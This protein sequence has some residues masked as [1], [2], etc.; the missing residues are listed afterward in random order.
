V[1][2][3]YKD[4]D[5]QRQATK[6]A[7]RR[8]RKSITNSITNKGI[9]PKIASF[10]VIPGQRVYGRQAVRYDLQEAW[11][12]RPEPE[13]SEDRPKPLNRGKYIKPD[14]SEYQIDATG[15]I[16][17][18]STKMDE[19]TANYGQP[20]CECMHCQQNR[21]SKHP[22]LINHGPYRPV[23]LLKHN[24]VNRVSLPGDV[25]YKGN[26]KLKANQAEIAAIEATVKGVENEAEVPEGVAPQGGGA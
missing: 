25:D 8:Y 12:L 7:T 13:S 17:R 26:D 11:D 18:L 1:I 21:R 20:N 2:M 23:E 14:G 24:E 9:T 22:R 16:H 10:E 4:K 6:E 15:V 3:P 19:L 5:K